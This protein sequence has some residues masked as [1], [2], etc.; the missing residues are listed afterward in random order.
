MVLSACSDCCWT[1]AEQTRPLPQ[2]GL[3]GHLPDANA[4]QQ[5]H[6]ARLPAAALQQPLVPLVLRCGSRGRQRPS[7]PF[8]V[9]MA[10]AVQ[11]GG[12]S[13]STK[14]G[15][16]ISAINSSRSAPDAANEWPRRPPADQPQLYRLPSSAR[17]QQHNGSG[18]INT[19]VLRRACR[20]TSNGGF[21][22]QAPKHW[23]RN[24]PNSA[25]AWPQPAD[26][27]TVAAGR[28]SC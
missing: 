21:Q 12:A 18:I 9:Q 10:C 2:A 26:T 19:G 17:G 6:P 13:S 28:V 11:Q 22:R 4:R 5:L 7:S 14:S 16:S 3:A 24:P 1:A 23:T 25:A 20:Q 27:C 15:S 8:G